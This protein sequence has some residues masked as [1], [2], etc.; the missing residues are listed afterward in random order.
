MLLFLFS[1]LRIRMYAAAYG[2]GGGVGVDSM[3]KVEFTNSKFCYLSVC[4]RDLTWL[5]HT[6]THACRVQNADIP[7][8]KPGAICIHVDVWQPHVALIA[9]REIKH[10]AFERKREVC[11]KI[12][13]HGQKTTPL[14][15]V[16][17]HK[18]W[19]I[20]I[21]VSSG[22][23][24]RSRRFSIAPTLVPIDIMIEWPKSVPAS[25]VRIHI[26][27]TPR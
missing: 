27:I 21:C 5:A 8:E 14:A 1:S 7:A 11:M 3:V 18:F 17:S 6:H 16:W 10:V 26:L 22:L 24:A 13:M 15:C 9:R 12:Q 2:N 19:T 23:F 25:V 20:I 4:H